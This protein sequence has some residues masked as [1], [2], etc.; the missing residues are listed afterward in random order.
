M[1]R[2]VDTGSSQGFRNIECYDGSGHSLQIVK[3]D[4]KYAVR[5]ARCGVECIKTPKRSVH[6]YGKAFRYPD[7]G[8]A[9]DCEPGD[10]L[11]FAGSGTAD[12]AFQ[13]E[14]GGQDAF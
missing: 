3:I 11:H 9:A 1:A 12:L 5:V 6:D 14:C 8:N 13:T 10:G 4:G 2:P 7:G